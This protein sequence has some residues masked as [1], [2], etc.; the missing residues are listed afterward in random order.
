MGFVRGVGGLVSF[1]LPCVFC[2]PG[3]CLLTGW[4]VLVMPPVPVFDKEIG[5]WK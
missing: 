4:V 3:L 5:G 1:A 2:P